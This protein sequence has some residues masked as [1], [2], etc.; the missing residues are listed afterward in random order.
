MQLDRN[1]MFAGMDALAAAGP[2]PSAGFLDGAAGG[3]PIMCQ[4]C[5]TTIDPGTGAPLSPVTEDAVVAVQR[6]LTAAGAALKGG[7]PL[8]D[9][10]ELEPALF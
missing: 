3:A 1:D 8:V 4:V 10:P 6:N 7:V 2:E 5:E 9:N